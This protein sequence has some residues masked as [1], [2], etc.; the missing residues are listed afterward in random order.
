MTPLLLALATIVAPQQAPS[1]VHQ[2]G[3][4]E[5]II[6]SQTVVGN[7]FDPDENDIEVVFTDP[8]GRRISVPAFYDGG[9]TWRVRFTPS[10][11]GTYRYQAEARGKT[12][13][14]EP[15]PSGTFRV[16][17]SSQPGFVRVDRRNPRRFALD[18][19]TP[20]YPVGMNVGWTSGGGTDLDYDTYFAAMGRAGL[21]W[22]RVWMC[23]WGGTNLEWTPGKL[24]LYNLDAARYIDRI[25]AEAER[26]GIY[27]QLVLQHHGQFSTRVNPNWADNPYSKANGGILDTPAGFFT[28]PKA[29]ELFKKR[30]RYV[31][32]R[33]GYST[34]LMAWELFNEVQF[35]D[36]GDWEDVAR[37]HDAAAS[38]IRSIDPYH[39]L[40]TTSSPPADSPVWRS[41][42]YLQ[43]HAYNDD[44][45]RSGAGD[46][47]PASISKPF[48]VGE[49]GASNG[50]GPASGGASFLRTGIYAGMLTGASAAPMFWAWDYVQRQNLYSVIGGAA[51][52]ARASGLASR[53]DLS[54]TPV[55]VSSSQLG[56]LTLTPALGWETGK[57]ATFA[58]GRQAQGTV[59]GMPS[60]IQGRAHPDMMPIPPTLVLDCPVDTNV[61]VTVRAVS[62]AGA[63]LVLTLDGEEVVRKQLAQADAPR[64][65]QLPIS[66]AVPSG[67]HQLTIAN[68]GQDWCQISSVV[69]ERYAPAIDARAVASKEAAVV[70]ARPVVGQSVDAE[71]RVRGL[72]AGRFR[73]ERYDTTTGEGTPAGEIE[74][75]NGVATLKIEKLGTD[76]AYVLRTSS[77]G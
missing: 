41:M 24:G 42:D 47:P 60:F 28:D 61:V 51:R 2:Y 35:T 27:V 31:V 25:L 34:H 8:S 18:G 1:T 55:A 77:R 72:N 32:A 6:T 59:A 10:S 54:P 46:L 67:R 36:H 5:L 76:A 29:R 22:A 62:A 23:A 57:E 69:I 64:G 21:N 74:V 63:E 73:V 37:W 66:V 52:F 70:W 65:R 14:A 49:W 48:F 15:A 40:I 33:W 19:G 7:P 45:L 9:T 56:P 20:F 71:V 13:L 4:F 26:N 68:D 38:Y 53:A 11:A 30:A 50:A 44:P 17:R 39:H 43:A 3:R 12:A 16:T 75:R 58:I